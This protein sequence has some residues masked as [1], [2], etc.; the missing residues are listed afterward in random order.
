[1]STLKSYVREMYSGFITGEYDIDAYWDTYIAE[2]EKIGISEVRDMYQE[3]Y[4]RVH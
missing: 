3:A 2:L 4:D 1:M